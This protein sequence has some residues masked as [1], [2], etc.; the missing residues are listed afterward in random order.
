MA[1]PKV[2]ATA[3]FGQHFHSIAR[4]MTPACPAAKQASC[5]LSFCR[6]C[7][8]SRSL[9]SQNFHAENKSC[10]RA[11]RDIAS[12][13]V[14]HERDEAL[15]GPF[16]HAKVHVYLPTWHTCIFMARAY[17]REVFSRHAV[18]KDAVVR[19]NAVGVQAEHERLLAGH[20]GGLQ[21]G[22]EVNLGDVCGRVRY[23]PSVLTHSVRTAYLSV[24]LCCT[25]ARY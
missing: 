10:L 5:V 4:L 13:H 9:L 22:V 7:P 3:R 6:P 15:A 14:L 25:F 11:P 12:L 17:V 19:Q 23:E 24:R 2:R 21:R 16:T 20:L 1:T 8:N 18:E